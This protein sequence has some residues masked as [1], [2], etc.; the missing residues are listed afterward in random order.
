MCLD[1]ITERYDRC[2]RIRGYVIRKKVG[3]EIVS[4]FYKT[5]YKL[6]KWYRA[7]GDYLLPRH[8]YTKTGT[9]FYAPGF[10]V[11]KN[12]EDA[13]LYMHDFSINPVIVKV[14]GY[15][16]LIGKQTIYSPTIFCGV[17]PYDADVYVCQSIY[18]HE[19][20]KEDKLEGN[21]NEIN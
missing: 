8:I 1:K 3:D 14:S 10:H 18:H 4:P 21:Q 12:K 16:K 5:T 9:Q 19:I 13:K 11:F 7:D 2:K 15:A 20:L 17:L 6:K